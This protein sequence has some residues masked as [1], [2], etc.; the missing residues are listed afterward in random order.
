MVFLKFFIFLNFVINLNAYKILIY[1]PK[2]GH[3]HINFM[4][5]MTKILIN[6]NHDVTVLSSKV[7][8]SLKDPYYQRGKIYYTDID[9]EISKL[10]SNEEHNKNIW[11]MSKNVTNSKEMFKNFIKVKRYMAESLIDNK[12]LKEFIISQNF[13]VGIAE[14][15]YP[16]MFGLF[17]YWKINTTIVTTTGIMFDHF[18]PMFGIPF[19]VSYVPSI[20]HGASDK[21]SYFERATNMFL[22]YYLSY[23]SGFI[24]KYTEMDDIFNE[25]F[26]VGFYDSQKIMTN[27][28]F[29]LINSNPFLDIPTPK[30]PKMIEISGI[31][32]P[33][34][35]P[36]SKELDKILN[37]RNKTILISFGSV[38]KSTYMNQKLKDEILKTIKSFPDITFIWKYETPEDGHGLGIDNLILK[39]WVPQNDLLNDKRLTLFITHGGMGS[40]T[41]A[42]FSNTPALAVPIFGDQM[43]NGKLLERLEIGMVV[44]SEILGDS[45]KFREKIKEVISNKKYKINLLKISTM[46]KNR[47]ISSE[48]LLIKHVEFACRFGQ[49]PQL[50][51]AS[52]DMG[53]IEY[54]NL[55]IIIPFITLCV[56]IFYLIFKLIFKNILKLFDSKKKQ[57]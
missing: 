31:G 47:P 8:D 28:S 54:Y 53:V 48:K 35:N 39:K 15:I 30:S 56:I 41:E 20:I 36:I 49:L 44:D 17:K 51:L 5:Q 50:D 33:K 27:A 9:P 7:D 10:I 55:D 24:S 43:R 45:K 46:L 29:V 22:H 12:E 21:M 19:P 40:I 52:K 32:I 18:Y 25:K 16:N 57:D 38:A 6:A 4:S 11:T 2:L 26:G 1:N 3:S 37:K 42:A 14:C 23:F 34:P 13:D